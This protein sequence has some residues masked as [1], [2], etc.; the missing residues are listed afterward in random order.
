VIKTYELVNDPT[1]QTL[2]GW[3]EEHDRRAFVVYDPVE[4][5]SSVLPRYFKHSNFCSFVRQL[6]IYGFHKIESSEGYAFQHEYF[7]VDSPHLLRHIQR[8]KTSHRK[9]GHASAQATPASAQQQP[10]PATPQTQ[11]Y[12]PPRPATMATAASP[13]QLKSAVVKMEPLPQLETGGMTPLPDEFAC[14]DP[15]RIAMPPGF[16]A[17]SPE[18]YRALVGEITKLQRQNG[19][20]QQTIRQLREILLQS[21]SR[22]EYLQQ[23]IQ[24]ISDYLCSKH[25]P[26]G[27]PTSQA[28][29]AELTRR[30]GTIPPAPDYSALQPLPPPDPLPFQSTQ[31]LGG[32]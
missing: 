22:E 28:D 2:V 24:I 29:I 6:N 10:P 1:T 9:S 8:K 20:T 26:G 31:P 14:E 17:E 18:I 3:S 23:R 19:D 13:H 11:A 5:A 15:S 12:A 25:I 32:I 16:A 30:L 21:R 4:F 27:A 7:R